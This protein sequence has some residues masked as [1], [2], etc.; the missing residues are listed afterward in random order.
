MCLINL[1][2]P[3]PPSHGR[4]HYS[5]LQSSKLQIVH[6]QRFEI[7]IYRP[8]SCD[9]WRN[10]SIEKMQKMVAPPDPPSNGLSRF[11]E[12]CN[13]D[14]LYPREPILKGGPGGGE[15]LIY[16]PWKGGPGGFRIKILGPVINSILY[17]LVRYLL[18][19]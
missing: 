10:F 3:A 13:F 9:F 4:A 2:P 7:T 16:F 15:N 14:S 17:C 19:I 8:K 5:T 11:D 18:K 6:P 12:D 1:S